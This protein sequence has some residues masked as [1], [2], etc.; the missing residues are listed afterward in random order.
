M[1]SKTRSGRTMAKGWA[2]KAADPNAATRPIVLTVEPCSNVLIEA[3]AK[4]CESWTSLYFRPRHVNLFSGYVEDSEMP[5]G[6]ALLVERFN[7]RVKA[8]SRAWAIATQGK[9]EGSPARQQS[10]KQYLALSAAKL[11]LIQLVEV[12][13]Q[14]DRTMGNSPKAHARA[15]ALTAATA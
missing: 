8:S 2:G 4:G 7:R 5:K 6:L 9:P 13:Y 3:P 1:N 14:K 10:Y 15:K 12:L 11:R